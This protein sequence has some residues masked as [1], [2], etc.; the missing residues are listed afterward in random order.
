MFDQL[1][2]GEC[3][4]SLQHCISLVDSALHFYNNGHFF[5]IKVDAAEPERFYSMTFSSLSKLDAY[6]TH[7]ATPPLTVPVE[8][9]LQ[10]HLFCFI[11]FIFFSFNLTDADSSDIT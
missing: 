8:S 11:F 10:T 6:I 1:V 7:D 9:G 4:D 5:N 3:L 2:K